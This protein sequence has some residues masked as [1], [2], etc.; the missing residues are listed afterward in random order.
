MANGIDRI[1]HFKAEIIEYGL[2]EAESGAVAVHL[3]VKL[4]DHWEFPEKGPGLGP[5]DEQAWIPWEI[6]DQ[7]AEGDVWLVKK[8]GTMNDSAVQSLIK[9]AGWDGD[10][11][12]LSEKRWQPIRC[13]VRI[14]AED[15]KE[16]RYYRIKYLNE[17]DRIPGK[18]QEM[19]PAKVKGLAA[20][21]GSATRAIYGTV[22]A[23]SPAPAGKPPAPKPVAPPPPV[24]NGGGASMPDDEIPFAAPCF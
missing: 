7:E 11:D 9:C 5:A 21:F 17:Y 14:D 12:A 19:E 1:G 2:K 10:W 4:L 6:Y 23:N 3:R 16:V 24:G 8:D 13:Q 18:F 20:R 15:Y 22:R